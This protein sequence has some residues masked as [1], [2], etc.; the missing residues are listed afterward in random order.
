MRCCHPA[1]RHSHSR[2]PFFSWEDSPLMLRQKISVFNKNSTLKGPNRMFWHIHRKSWY[3]PGKQWMIRATK[4]NA[5]RHTFVTTNHHDGQSVCWGSIAKITPQRCWRG[6]RNVGYSFDFVKR[7]GVSG[8]LFVR[9]GASV[10]IWAL[11]HTATH[12]NT[13]RLNLCLQLYECSPKLSQVFGFT[14]RKKEWVSEIL[15][16]F[17]KWGM[18]DTATRIC[19]LQSLQR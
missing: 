3:A 6:W 1:A 4:T 16:R 17:S 7:V 11:Q 13:L 10:L 8:A 9:G 12:C 2:E 5:S 19:M 14:E 15:W 18:Q